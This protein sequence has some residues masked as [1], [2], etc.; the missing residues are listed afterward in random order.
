MKN[1]IIIIAVLAIVGIGSYYV[2]TN[3]S[4][5]KTPA[6]IPPSSN[7]QDINTSIPLTKTD[8]TTAQPHSSSVSNALKTP[9]ISNVNV[10]IKNFS[11]NPSSLKVKTGT[12][13]TWTNN[14]G[15][16]H[17]IT[18]DS[19]TILNSKTISPGES[20]SFTFADAG[21]VN[22]HCNIHPMMK[23]VIVIEK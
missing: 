23:G 17:T 15:V 22:Y 14:D 19:G 5:I 11:F 9:I 16:S 12:K 2:L 4:S 1:T 21:S 7:T 3:N 6:Y 13:V 18:S 20:F 10:N 8:T